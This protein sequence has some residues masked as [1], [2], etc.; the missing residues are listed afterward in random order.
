MESKTYTVDG[1]SFDL[2]HHGV[3][4]MKWGRRKA[5]LQAMGAG[6]RSGR[7]AD[8]PEAQTSAKEARRRKVKRAAAIGAAAVGTAL[9]AYG[10]Y[11]I[12]K[13]AKDKATRR[14]LDRGYE[15]AQ[16]MMQQRQRDNDMHDRIIE[17][18]MK[19]STHGSYEF[20]GRRVIW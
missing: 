8:S 17:E 11:K 2:R 18:M 4:G 19:G 13:L 5:R 3:K 9:A 20:G 15:A 12:T 16:R 1:K 10:A 14:R 6:R 7:I